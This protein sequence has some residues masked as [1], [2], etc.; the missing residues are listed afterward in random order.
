[1]GQAQNIKLLM[2]LTTKLGSEN[3]QELNK[4]HPETSCATVCWFMFAAVNY[5]RKR[6]KQGN[7]LV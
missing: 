6:Q 5:L 1:M 4:C 3:E 7:S 2:V